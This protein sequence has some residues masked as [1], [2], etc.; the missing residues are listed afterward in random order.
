[1]PKQKVF[2]VSEFLNR[3]ISGRCW[4]CLK[5]HS[6]ETLVRLGYLFVCEVH[7]PREMTRDE[8]M[9]SLRHEA[10]QRGTPPER[11]EKWIEHDLRWAGTFGR[12]FDEDLTW[13]LL[14]L[15]TVR[16]VDARHKQMRRR[17]SSYLSGEGSELVCVRCG[18]GFARVK[19]FWA[20]PC[21]RRPNHR[22]VEE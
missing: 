17:M 6:E 19:D 9:G 8:M 12:T 22:R 10:L 18:G 2:S 5:E 14:S 21:V 16:M 20:H 4:I 7:L 13:S 1:M 11:L 3:K 15:K